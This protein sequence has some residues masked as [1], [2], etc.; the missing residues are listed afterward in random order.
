MN[1]DDTGQRAERIREHG[2][3]VVRR[4]ADAIRGVAQAIDQSFVGAT[5][6][7]L[8][9]AGRVICLGVGKSGIIARKMAASLASLGTPAQF[10]HAADALHGDL[11][12]IT[13]QDVVVALSHSGTTA[14]VLAAVRAL[15]DL[16]VPLI[17]V[18]DQQESPLADAADVVLCPGVNEEADPMGLAP[19]SSTTATLVMTDALAVAA[20]QMRGFT[21]DDFHRT[22]PG[23][24]LGAQRGRG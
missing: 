1:H 22:H 18:T 19:T 13:A 12:M 6:L 23:G 21:T 16:G 10:I 8:G 3:D 5:E 9:C 24:A 7:L 4:E 2:H 15:A 14:E 20:S 11:G 17:A